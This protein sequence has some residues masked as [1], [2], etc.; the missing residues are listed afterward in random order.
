MY[1]LNKALDFCVVLMYNYINKVDFSLKNKKIPTKNEVV[2]IDTAPFVL[3]H[4]TK[5]FSQKQ[6]FLAF[7]YSIQAKMRA[8]SFTW[9]LKF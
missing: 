9:H 4:Y 8:R 1:K 3:K 5:Y 2:Y 6:V 7:F